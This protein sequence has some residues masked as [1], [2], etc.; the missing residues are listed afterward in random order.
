ME[1]IPLLDKK[2]IVLGVTGGIAA[3]KICSLAS[4]LTKAGAEVD[5]VMTGAAQ[6]F[7]EPLT[8]EA[9]TGRTVY[10]S[11]WERAGE[12]LPTHVAHVGLGHAADLLV[13]APATA[14]I[15]AKLTV[16]IAD[17]LL[18]TLALAARCPLIL[19][20]SMDVGMW[21]HAAT[22][23]NVETLV[24]RGAQLAGP[25]EGRM[26]S[27]LEGTG[28]L[29]E[30]DEILGHIRWVLGQEGPLAGRKMVVTAGPTREYLDPVRFL[31]NPSSGRQGYALAQAAV[32]R[33]AEV[34]LVS[35]PTHLDPPVGA[36]LVGVTSVDEMLQAVMGACEYADALLM[37]AAVGDYRT[38][39]R[40]REKVKKDVKDLSLDLERTTDVLA[41]VSERRQA[42]GY[43]RVLVGF[44]AETG[45]LIE[46]ARAK[47]D[48]KDLDLVVANDVTQPEAG[49]GVPTNRVVLVG[50][51]GG[52]DELPVMSKAAVAEVV[53]DRIV[54][55]L[56][57]QEDEG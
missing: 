19:A 22:Q 20:P 45:N 11:L 34:T 2:R 46:Y 9:L 24:E 53:L 26:A 51:Q 18:T 5:V 38:R 52:A 48:K 29:L 28:R 8:F 10:T 14:D 31:S 7:V 17:D 4:R 15:M 23:A 54:A 42:S 50:R 3:Y 1:T 37:A 40:A 27:G 21:A 36:E 39:A 16:G 30:P 6:R 41:A 25:A 49:F 32:D 35:G 13:V 44:A 47:L 12:G 56:V 55:R 43:P 57:G 33:G